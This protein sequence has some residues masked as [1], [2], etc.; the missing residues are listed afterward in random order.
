MCFS[1]YVTT[2]LRI[3]CD[4]EGLNVENGITSAVLHT[5]MLAECGGNVRRNPKVSSKR[6][7]A[8]VT[9][10]NQKRPRRSCNTAAAVELQRHRAEC[11]LGQLQYS[12]KHLATS[13]REMA[14]QKLPPR[15]KQ[16]LLAYM[17]RV[18]AEPCQDR[19]CPRAAHSTIL[20]TAKKPSIA[21]ES[22]AARRVAM[23]ADCRVRCRTTLYGRGYQ[24]CMNMKGLRFYT[25]QQADCRAAAQHQTVLERLH[26]MLTAAITADP[27]AWYCPES[28]TQMCRAV[29][30]AC[31]TSEATLGL[32]VF[33]HMKASEWLGQRCSITS[34]VLPLAE[35]LALHSR[36]LLARRSSWEALR[37][38]CVRLLQDKRRLS[39]V[40]AEA[41]V[42][43]ARR[44][45]ASAGLARVVHSV[46]RALAAV[47][48]R[49][50]QAARVV[51]QQQRMATL[52]RTK[53]G[54]PRMR[55]PAQC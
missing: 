25:R 53:V 41:A 35:A 3:P 6:V 49:A 51:L 4:L 18:Q 54:R 28:L 12:L 16:A 43:A 8:V 22:R 10:P 33:V 23:P 14:I 27:E 1:Q 36:L 21:R 20:R 17:E 42:D 38:E 44:A 55:Q 26:Q 32:G 29:L 2:D 11:T 34:Q 45:A 30:Q 24:A 15:V 39:T 31:G 50:A 48:R 9:S 37:V 46:E 40:E 47:E 13:Q 52:R 7:A 5:G 19:T